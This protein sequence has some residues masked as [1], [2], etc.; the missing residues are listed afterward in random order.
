M[1]HGDRDLTPELSESTLISSFLQVTGD[2]VADRP[3]A[4]VKRTE[5]VPVTTLDRLLRNDP[6]KPIFLK[7]TPK[8]Y[9]PDAGR[10][11]RHH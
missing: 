4:R 11:W 6:Y 5:R 7:A 10:R 1:F 2:Y 9:D 3:P 8:G